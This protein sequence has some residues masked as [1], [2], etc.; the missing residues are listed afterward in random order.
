M[1]GGSGGRYVATFDQSACRSTQQLFVLQSELRIQ[2]DDRRAVP[3]VHN[4]VRLYCCVVPPSVQHSY[5]Q[6]PRYS[7]IFFQIKL[8]IIDVGTRGPNLF[9]T[10]NFPYYSFIVFIFRCVLPLYKFS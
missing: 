1:W 10:Y 2:R 8:Y 5:R 3:T 4:A 6:V 9:F 7:T